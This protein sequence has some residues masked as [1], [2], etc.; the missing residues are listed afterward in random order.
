MPL[1]ELV[2]R[3]A[4]AAQSAQ[5]SLDEHL[6]YSPPMARALPRVTVEGQYGIRQDAGKTLLLFGHRKEE[7]ET[8]RVNFTL[9]LSPEPMPPL[10]IQSM[11]EAALY[12]PPYIEQPAVV[13]QLVRDLRSALSSMDAKLFKD[14]IR[15][16]DEAASNQ[17]DDPG[18][19]AFRLDG[20]DAY[21]I[22]RIG[23]RRDGIF[24]FDRSASP[25]VEVISHWRSDGDTLPWA[26]FHRLFESLRAWQRGSA[27]PRRLDGPLPDRVGGIETNSFLNPMWTAYRDARKLLSADS[28]SRFSPLPAYYLI[29]K[30]GAMLSYS[31]PRVIGREPDQQPQLVKSDVAVT[32]RKDAGPAVVELRLRAPEYV[33][34]DDQKKGILELLRD[35]LDSEEDSI[36]STVDPGYRADYESALRDTARAADSLVLLSYRD[37]PPKNEFLFIWTGSFD[38]EERDFAFRLTLDKDRL[39]DPEIVLKLEDPVD[40]S[41]LAI[42]MRP[43]E[44]A[45]VPYGSHAAGLHDFFHAA[46]IWTIMGGWFPA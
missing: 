33:L 26:P 10:D 25:A 22:V 39:R 45:E 27:T 35:N 5:R 6:V 44:L 18:L 29:E 14:E 3:A 19:V 11:P 31:I 15:K 4:E 24:L 1:A 40:G 28:G 38:S 34:V 43:F 37:Q 8:Y 21:M 20:G 23:G 32:V 13:A 16:L 30:M 7:Q 42:E 41:E 12:V 17:D 9:R 2:V 46:W 36:L